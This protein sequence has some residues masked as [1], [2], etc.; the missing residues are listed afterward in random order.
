[1]GCF[2]H[3]FAARAW[4]VRGLGRSLWIT[5]RGAFLCRAKLLAILWD[6]EILSVQVRGSHRRGPS[7]ELVSIVAK[8]VFV[9]ERWQPGYA[10]ADRSGRDGPLRLPALEHAANERVLALT[11]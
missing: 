4:V 9:R 5:A 8:P 3:R 11:Q 2:C 10:G 6:G 1:M 7:Y